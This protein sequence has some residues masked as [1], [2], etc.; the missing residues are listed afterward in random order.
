MSSDSQ[1][2]TSQPNL[3]PEKK[4]LFDRRLNAALKRI[5]GE[6][7]PTRFSIPRKVWE[8]QVPMSSI[9]ERIWL[10][11]MLVPDWPIF[12][13]PLAL[14]LHGELDS[15]AVEEALNRILTRHSV[16][17]SYYMEENGLPVQYISPAIHLSIKLFDLTHREDKS[18]QLQRH[19][20]DIAGYAFDLSHSPPVFARL[21][22]LDFQEYILLLS[23]HHISF[24]GWSA[25]L[26]INELAHF[27]TLVQWEKQPAGANQPELPELPIQ[28]ADF[29]HWERQRQQGHFLKQLLDYWKNQLADPPPPLA[30]PTDHPRT[31]ASVGQGNLLHFQIPIEVMDALEK[32]ALQ[33]HSTLF[34]LLLA[35]FQVL[36]YRYTGQKDM[37]IGAPIAGRDHLEVENLIGIFIRLLPFRARFSESLTF[38]QFLMQVRETALA[39]YAHQE[40]PYEHLIQEL[41]PHR[42]G[43]QPVLFQVIF[44]LENLPERNPP[45]NMPGGLIFEEIDIAS[46]AERYDLSL[47]II[48]SSVL[49]THR[50]GLSCTLSYN[51][52]LFDE[53]RMEGLIRHYLQLL[54]SILSDIDCLVSKLPILTEQERHQILIEWNYTHQDFPAAC[55]IH[56]LFETQAERNPERLAVLFDNPLPDGSYPS[57]TYHALNLRAN[58]LAHYLQRQGVGPDGIVG[59]Y[60]ERSLEMVIALLGILKA[61]GAY[62]PLE[63]DYPQKR[64]QRIIQDANLS[65]IITTRSLGSEFVDIPDMPELKILCLDRE[66]EMLE[67]E[68]IE[69]CHSQV[70]PENLIYIIYT[71]G[72]TG[73]PKGV[74]MSH[75]ALYNHFCWSAREFSL[76]ADEHILQKSSLSF[77]VSV[78]EVLWPITVGAQ[79]ILPPPGKQRDFQYLVEAI[80]RHHVTV[81]QLVPIQLQGLLEIEQLKACSSLRF[82]FC[83]GEVMQPDLP[84]FFYQCLPHACLVNMYG[85]TETCDDATFWRCRNEAHL[86]ALPIGRPIANFSAYILDSQLEPVPVGIPGELYL[87]G[88][89]LARGYLNRPEITAEHFVPDPF[90]ATG[91]QSRLYRTGDLVAYQPAGE[92]MFLGRIDEQVKLRGF[93]I[94]LGEIETCLTSHPAIHQAAVIVNQDVSKNQNLVAYLVIVPDSVEPSLPELRRFLKEHLPDYMIPTQYVFLDALPFTPSNKINRQALPAPESIRTGPHIQVQP[95]SDDVERRL[96]EI[97]IKVLNQPH[98]STTENFFDLGGHSLLAMKLAAEISDEFGTYLP[99][100]VVFEAPTVVEIADLIRVVLPSKQDWN[101]D[102]LRHPAQDRESGEL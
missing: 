76:G 1:R 92:I 79:V 99:V 12:N 51:A 15:H 39:A 102:R 57:L 6:T 80:Q 86:P 38:R 41:R 35:A 59:V 5:D 29:A 14:K 36:L 34:M 22:R 96:V 25:R 8:G 60:L 100:R 27:Y 83:G 66:I 70:T 53:W 11:Q 10:E 43:A 69:N 97:W 89:G 44:N 33:E 95:P 71:S 24:D 72:S 54:Q 49:Q 84:D 63:V 45:Q 91:S 87:G 74:L 68:A 17:R 85:P 48:R 50:S 58:Q 32:L 77:D 65:V 19:I 64:L 93:R 75:C 13:R 81:L 47:E 31:Q 40:L 82:I 21:L 46:M 52:E 37:I 42:I 4:K 23:F 28:Y 62:L 3:S 61:G 56:T 98:I 101:T 18:Q 2:E 30:L 67:K 73:Q 26:F 20:N 55:P 88:A 9:Q 16:L 78:W 90:N 7:Q 94:E